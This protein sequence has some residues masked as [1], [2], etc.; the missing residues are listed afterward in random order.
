MSSGIR[1]PLWAF[2]RRDYVLASASRLAFAWHVV[3]VGIAVPTM[4][5][6]G[7]LLRPAAS[8]QLAPYGGDY[9]A[10][11]VVGVAVMT[12]GA[13]T[14]GACA[15]AVRR[16][17]LQGTLDVVL[18]SPTAPGTLALGASLWPVAMAAVEFT[19]YLAVGAVIFHLPIRRANI[20]SASVLL[21]LTFGV[22]AA[23]GTLTAAFVLATRR[24][25]AL[26]GAV[27]SASVLLAGVFYP[28]TVLPPTLQ[29]TSALVPL[30]YALHGLRLALLR[31]DG[32]GV[33]SGDVAA[34][35]VFLVI[36]WPAAIL[37]GRLALA[38]LRRTGPAIG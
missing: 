34:L 28:T 13:A 2:L 26:T 36:L 21:M 38:H 27:T 30:T 33:L 22:F 29:S 3:A 14:M 12:L 32:L 7:V 10:F 16:E 5:Y 25:D 20:L 37:A 11:V 23:L 19:L 4:Y 9:F 6:L 1:A 17:Q 15:A 24:P 8:P 35:A 31:G 18:A